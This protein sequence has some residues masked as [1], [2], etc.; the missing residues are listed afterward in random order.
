MSIQDVMSITKNFF[1]NVMHK[2]GQIIGVCKTGEGWTVEIEVIE[3]DEYMRR[4][5]RN[6]LL[7]IYEIELDEKPEI[8]CYKR[9]KLRERGKLE[10]HPQDP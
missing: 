6:E 9:V 5:G 10:F 4:H 7:G 1:E 2:P 3:E 8:I